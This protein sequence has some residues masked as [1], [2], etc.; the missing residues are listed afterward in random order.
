MRCCYTHNR[1]PPP[2]VGE[3]AQ[4]ALRHEPAYRQDNPASMVVQKPQ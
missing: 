2:L 4:C 1:V 3:G